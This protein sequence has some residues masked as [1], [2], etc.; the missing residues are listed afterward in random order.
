M[1]RFSNF[2]LPLAVL[3]PVFVVVMGAA[4]VSM[5]TA[6]STGKSY[7]AVISPS[8]ATG[9][10][11]QTFTYTVTDK[12]AQ[13]QL[14][15]FRIFIP[16]STWNVTTA[17]VSSAPKGASSWTVSSD[18][19]QLGYIQVLANNNAARLGKEQS[20][21]VSFTVASVPCGGGVFQ[22]A[23]H[24]ANQFNGP[25]NEFAQTNPDSART[26]TT[27]GGAPDHFTISTAPTS[28]A[29]TYRAG[30]AFG[31]TVT[32]FDA[33]NNQLT[34]YTGSHGTL[35]GLGTSPA[36][37][38]KGPDGLGPLTFASGAATA[39]ATTYLKG[40]Q[41]LT[42]T[43]GATASTSLTAGPGAALGGFGWSTQPGSSYTAGGT[44]TAALTAYD[45][46]S[47]V[48]DDYTGSHG[49]LSGLGVS[50]APVSK[51]PDGLGAQ[52]F[53]AG[54]ANVS[55]VDYR[56][57]TTHFDFSADAKAAPASSSFTVSPDTF[58][59]S[60]AK[61]PGP[62]LPNTPIP[63]TTSGS[64]PTVHV[65]DQYG[66]LAPDGTTVTM[67]AAT[68]PGGTSTPFSAGTNPGSVTGGTGNA[69]FADLALATLGTYTLT[70]S[71]TGSAP[72]TSNPFSI[73]SV[74]SN[75]SGTTCENV[76]SN[77]NQTSYGKITKTDAL[78][79]DVV[80]TTTFLPAS[81]SNCG[82]FGAIPGTNVTDLS[83]F[84]NVSASKPSF[85]VILITPK[86][87]LQ[88]AGYTQRSAASFD[89][90]VGVKRLDGGDP[91]LWT[92]KAGTPPASAP[93]ADGFSWGIA[94]DCT[95][96]G[97]VAGNPCV[98]LKTKQLNALLAYTG[99]SLPAGVTFNNS[100]LALVVE[101]G[102]PFDLR[103][104]TGGF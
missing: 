91:S 85:S 51:S 93:D 4:A 19:N 14:G 74:L 84:G 28:P 18:W 13:Q 1:R 71:R 92:T 8:V 76:L 79:S 22:S 33:C 73:V 23:A 45:D 60:F 44:I 95:Q 3:V 32:A 81:A 11:Q 66:N 46:W 30:E 97:L 15:S 37:V 25:N 41:S 29:T 6:A 98:R 40:T 104:S 21:V 24:Q 69:T 53:T 82:A 88:A 64:S 87:T 10:T 86:S 5:G 99:G 39:T 54:V 103:G 75:C 49:T 16:A 27:S 83:V 78:F 35:S 20:V 26:V 89:V 52:T 62:A 48:K 61:Q 34:T 101:M 90:C 63:G 65:V 36:P 77:G 12:D 72:V 80:L 68:Y 2:R 57:E 43:D 102:Y 67:G 56:A 38:S 9:G 70:A 55:A 96:S 42:Y 58:L 17:S 100:D 7:W 94:P 59:L 47:N 31:V 50:P